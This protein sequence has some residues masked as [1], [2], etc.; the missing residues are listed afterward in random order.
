MGPETGGRLDREEPIEMV[1]A[2]AAL[3]P[4]VTTGPGSS[5]GWILSNRKC[6]PSA[7]RF[8]SSARSSSNPTILSSSAALA[9]NNQR[10]WQLRT[11]DTVVVPS[12]AA[13]LQRLV[14]DEERRPTAPVW[15]HGPAPRLR[16]RAMAGLRQGGPS[17]LAGL[18]ARVLRTLTRRRAAPHPVPGCAARP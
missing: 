17:A 1:W 14:S 10:S 16:C 4:A 12:P 11:G 8:A 7:T 9:Y 5:G 18:V 15:F 2:I 13:V 6:S 3:P